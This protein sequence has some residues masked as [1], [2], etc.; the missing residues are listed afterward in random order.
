[1]LYWIHMSWSVVCCW[2]WLSKYIPKKNVSQ[3]RFKT[4]GEIFSRREDNVNWKLY[5]HLHCWQGEEN[6][7][8]KKKIYPWISIIQF[9]KRNLRCPLFKYLRHK[10]MT[11]YTQYYWTLHDQFFFYS[12]VFSTFGS[13]ALKERISDSECSA[14][15]LKYSF[16][17]S[18]AEQ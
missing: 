2:W 5:F 1:M 18:C 9:L 11:Y 16:T 15:Y 17:L 12:V 7:L 8:E 14:W 13:E 4:R 6:H 10:G 3:E